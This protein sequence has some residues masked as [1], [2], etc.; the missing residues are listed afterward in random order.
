[1]YSLGVL[2]SFFVK[3]SNERDLLRSWDIALP[4]E[5]IS[6]GRASCPELFF[7]LL[8]FWGGRRFSKCKSFLRMKLSST[9]RPSE[10][11]L[12]SEALT[13]FKKVLTEGRTSICQPHGIIHEWVSLNSSL[14]E[15]CAKHFKNSWKRILSSL[16]S[17]KFFFDFLDFVC[18]CVCICG[19]WV[20]ES[21]CVRGNSKAQRQLN[22]EEAIT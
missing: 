19:V 14:L 4:S 22:V 11:R 10:N 12:S 16:T 8:S 9:S 18:V 6:R 20:W 15:V 13:D 17:P 7:V 3:V 5:E 1:M 21:L 2:F